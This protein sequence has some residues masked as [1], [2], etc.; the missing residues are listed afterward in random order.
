MA[1]SSIRSPNSALTFHRR[2]V[3]KSS[4]TRAVCCRK[5][6][7]SRRPLPRPSASFHPRLPAPISI[8]V[9]P[10]FPAPVIDDFGADCAG[11]SYL[12]CTRQI[13]DDHFRTV[14]DT[15]FALARPSSIRRRRTGARKCHSGILS[16]R[17][18]YCNNSTVVN[19]HLASSPRTIER[20]PGANRS[21]RSNVPT[22]E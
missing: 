18:R 4:Q 1:S 16:A 17:T 9:C 10:G 22:K 19:V 21:A 12:P 13:P 6:T 11:W 3:T 5:N 14:H 20:N 2:P 7:T 15:A 8:N